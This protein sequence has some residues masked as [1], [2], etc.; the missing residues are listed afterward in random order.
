[1]KKFYLHLVAIAGV[2]LLSSSAWVRLT[3]LRPAVMTFP[4]EIQTLVIVDRTIPADERRNAVEEFLTGE[5]MRQDEQGV[6]QAIDG[7]VKTL[8][9]APRFKVE[10]S[11]D[12]LIGETSGT[13][14]PQA[15]NWNTIDRL[16]SKYKAD[17]VVAIETYDSDYIITDGSRK[18]EKKDKDGNVSVVVEYFAEGVGTVN[19]GFRFYD[20]AQR[21]ILDQYQFSEQM[22][23]D[24]QGSTPAAAIEGMMGKV[25]AINEIS[26]SAGAVYAQR[27]SPTYYQVKRTFFDRPKKNKY[28]EEGVRK[29]KVADWEGAI[30]SWKM[31]IKKGKKDKDKGR[32]AYNIAVAYEVLGDYELALEWAAT[33]Y[34]QYKEKDADNYHR[35]LKNVIREREIVKNQLGE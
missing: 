11:T 1:M 15:L 28:L 18:V 33:S 5:F 12:K 7:F 26:Y 31:A 24:A 32:A 20:P 4:A 3:Y 6:Q 25:A 19:L 23:W 13:I 30:E 22:R 8:H 2:I 21:S 16:C 35:V 27:I 17:A 29:S 10:Y 14:F 9:N 34:T